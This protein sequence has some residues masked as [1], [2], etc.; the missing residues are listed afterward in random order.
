MDTALPLSRQNRP[1]ASLAGG[2]K[3]NLN[4]N[5][6]LRFE[7]RFYWMSTDET[8][9]VVRRNAHRDC[10]DPCTYTYRFGSSFTQGEFLLGLMLSP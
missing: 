6:G 9:V 8:T 2:L 4:K 5:L 10:T 3:T 7:G 1:S